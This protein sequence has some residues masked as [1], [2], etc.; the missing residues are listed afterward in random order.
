MPISFEE[1]RNNYK[2]TMKRVGQ[3]LD[4]AL[5]ETI[6][7]VTRQRDLAPTKGPST[8][9]NKWLELLY[10]LYARTFRK[11]EYTTVSFRKGVVGDFKEFFSDDDLSYFDS[12]AHDAMARLGYSGSAQTAVKT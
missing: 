3:F 11:I 10:K 12:I 9:V 6:V 4:L 8:P 2:D 1:L 5:P 7:E